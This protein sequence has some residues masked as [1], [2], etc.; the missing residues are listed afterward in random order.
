MAT[1]A[2][3]FDF[4]ATFLVAL[5][6]SIH[7]AGMCGGFALAASIDGG[8][9][10]LKRELRVVPGVAALRRQFFYHGGKTLSY[11][12]LGTVSVAFGSTLL[13]S[14]SVSARV[15]A[16]LAGA[17]LIWV[18]LQTL[19]GAARTSVL[20]G[21]A[22]VLSREWGKLGARGLAVG[23]LLRPL[24]LGM[25]SGLLPCP[26]VYAFLGRA[27]ATHHL[28]SALAGMLALG[29]GSAPILVL[30]GLGGGVTS[31]P[32]LRRW[33]KASGLLL[34]ALGIWT[35]HRGW[36]APACCSP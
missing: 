31:P 9:D 28:P 13:T 21:W 36:V 19:T 26:L 30:V 12:F 24:Y 20:V 10:G 5:G 29:L 16:G 2:E 34:V 3:P 15:L 25:F 4:V 27:A 14:G 23:T 35:V 17:F 32:V 11:V 6:A 7:C 18:G 22:K 33:S 8:E 1:L